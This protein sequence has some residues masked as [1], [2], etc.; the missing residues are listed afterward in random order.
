MRASYRAGFTIVELLIVIV[1][2]AILATI[3]VVA[4]S[5]VQARARDSGRV[6]RIQQI[7]KAIELYRI[8]NGQYPPIEDGAGTETSCGSQTE[9]WGH[10][11]RMKQLAD[12]LAPYMKI[13]PT[14]LSSATQG[15]YNYYYNSA[16]TDGFGSYGFRVALEG[17]GGQSD[18]GYYSSS[19]EVGPDPTYCMSAYTGADA[20]W[21]W[22]SAR[23][24]CIGGN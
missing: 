4:Y 23:T 19:F 1:V 12:Y 13:D 15:V 9:N 8:D 3:S 2:I 11:D 21:N 5:G 7:A 10:C 20:R 6:S 16:Q 18:G 22:S 17:S 14:S 24:R